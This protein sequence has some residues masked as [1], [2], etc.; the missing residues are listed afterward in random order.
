MSFPYGVRAY[1]PNSSPRGFAAPF[2]IRPR[3]LEQDPHVVV[4]EN[5][6]AVVGQG[7]A[8]EVL[9]QGQPSLPVVGGNFA[10]E[11]HLAIAR[12]GDQGDDLAATRASNCSSR[13]KP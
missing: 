7:R 5:L 13:S 8:K 10:D 3:L 9:A 2:T 12:G 6:E 4:V 11:R 1:P